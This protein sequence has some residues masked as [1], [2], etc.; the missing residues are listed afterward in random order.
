MIAS[1]VALLL[2]QAAAVP[3]PGLQFGFF[4]MA[5][6]RQRVQESNCPADLDALEVLRRRLAARFGKQAFA[7]PKV[8]KTP[9]GDCSVVSNVYSVNLAD[10]R[11]EAEA[12][13]AGPVPMAL[14][15]PKAGGQ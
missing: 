13:L 7:W 4:R 10:F 15:A 6:F 3:P 11:K 8:P 5:A 9:G 1:A 2:A 12:A 14:N